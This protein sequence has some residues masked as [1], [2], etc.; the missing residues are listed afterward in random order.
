MT[1]IIAH[2]GYYIYSL[3]VEGF[4]LLVAAIGGVFTADAHQG[5]GLASDLV[6][7]CANKAKAE[8]CALVFL[9]T[10]NHQFYEKIG[11]HLVGRQWTIRLNQ[12]MRSRLSKLAEERGLAGNALRFSEE[13]TDA[14]LEQSLGLLGQLPLGVQRSFTDHKLLLRSGACRIFSAWQDDQLCAYFLI[15]KG[16]DL[17]G[18]VHE[19]AGQEAA[20]LHL[21]DH[22]LKTKPE[23][24]LLS[25]QWM[26]EEC[27]FIY[28]LEDLSAAFSAEY[29]GLARLLDFPSIEKLL[30]IYL[31]CFGTQTDDWKLEQAK[32]EYIFTWKTEK[33]VFSEAE[34]MK[35]LFGAELP[36]KDEW[37]AIFP[38]RPWFWG[39]D[40]V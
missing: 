26:P 10:D 18:Y 21:C 17:Q 33:Q 29:M 31:E 2:A 8:G 15:G 25:P 37:K 23:F 32:S 1:Q 13:A 34:L 28:D 27:A 20:L 7:L 12:A 40:S 38:L 9:W 22:V 19:W 14:F 35:L 24:R 30:H 3:L 4:P 39:M 11:F 16:K 5:Q 36:Q 6:N